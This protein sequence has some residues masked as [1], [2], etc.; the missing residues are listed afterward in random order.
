[1]FQHN[2]HCLLAGCRTWKG[3]VAPRQSWPGRAPASGVRQRTPMALA[4][5]D[6]TV[7]VWNATS[8]EQVL[9][10]KGHT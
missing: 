4:L 6:Q 8:G 2:A 1:M 5:D 3:E 10:L 7:V 9:T